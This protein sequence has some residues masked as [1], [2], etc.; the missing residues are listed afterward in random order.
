MEHAEPVPGCIETCPHL[1]TVLGSCGSELR[2]LLVNYLKEH[3]D[4]TCPV[5][6]EHRAQEMR[7][8]AQQIEQS[9]N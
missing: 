2:S 9:A 6:D 7:K 4:V 1:E 8:L 5:Y 3:P